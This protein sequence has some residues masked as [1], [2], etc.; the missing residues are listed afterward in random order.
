MAR[1][2]TPPDASRRRWLT[3]A[4]WRRLTRWLPPSLGCRLHAMLPDR[5]ERQGWNALADEIE[6]MRN[7]ARVAEVTHISE[8]VEAELERLRKAA[9]A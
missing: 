4:R 3:F 1:V 5:L 2:P 9:G 8:T 7:A 6:E